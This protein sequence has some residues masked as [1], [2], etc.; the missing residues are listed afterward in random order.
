MHFYFYFAAQ[1]GTG[2]LAGAAIA[3]AAGG[4]GAL[5]C[6]FFFA[7]STVI[8]W[9]FFGVDNVKYLFGQKAVE[10]VK[11]SKKTVDIR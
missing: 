5:F 10:S 1:A 9:Y 3:I 11:N 7:F 2:N 4:P 6:M 8:G